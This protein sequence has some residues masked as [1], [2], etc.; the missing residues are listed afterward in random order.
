MKLREFLKPLGTEGASASASF[1]TLG[2]VICLQNRVEWDKKSRSAHYAN[3]LTSQKVI[4]L[5][6]SKMR[7]QGRNYSIRKRLW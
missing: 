2:W 5:R 1:D 7:G 3:P 6:A 4:M